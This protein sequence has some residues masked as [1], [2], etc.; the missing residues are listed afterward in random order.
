LC[1]SNHDG[2][3][4]PT[5]ESRGKMYR[6]FTGDTRMEQFPQK[7]DC[8][9][10]D[11]SIHHTAHG[12]PGPCL[13]GVARFTGGRILAPIYWNSEMSGGDVRLERVYGKVI[14]TK[15][16]WKL[17][18]II[19]RR[20][21]CPQLMD[22]GRHDSRW[23]NSTKPDVHRPY[24]KTWVN[25]FRTCRKKINLSKSGSGTRMTERRTWCAR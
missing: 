20:G 13:G 5:R 4:F 9:D 19:R 21:N 2:M 23:R 24:P 10:A 7:S 3:E 22:L 12:C 17:H 25:A 14:Q 16:C 1:R 11:Q 18:F 15:P 6:G 8:K